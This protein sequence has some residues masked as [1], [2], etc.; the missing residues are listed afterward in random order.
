MVRRWGEGVSAVSQLVL[1]ERFKVPEGTDSVSAARRWM[2]EALAP[3][4]L[5]RTVLEELKVAVSE[6]TTNA[7]FHGRRSETGLPIEIHCRV[8]PARLVIEVDA[9]GEPFVPH[10]ITLPDIRDGH[11]RGRGLFLMQQFVD[12]LEFLPRERGVRVR[13]VKEL[14]A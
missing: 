3:L 9:E 7:M 6:A 4:Q 12:R 11:P 14:P 5:P 1:E 10:E 2:G 8:E 13:L